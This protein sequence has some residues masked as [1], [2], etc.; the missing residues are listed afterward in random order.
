M[1]KAAE[2]EHMMHLG[3]SD[4]A[5]TDEMIGFHAQQAVEKCLKGVLCLRE[6]RYR[7]THEIA[8][9]LDLL[10]DHGI[11]FP[12]GLEQAV[13]LTP[14]AAEL[15]YDYLPPEREAEGPFDRAAVRQTVRDALEWARG[16]CG[17]GSSD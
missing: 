8:E 14:F 15:R 11:A 3:L 2:D 5:V 13:E 10:R 12:S 9:L 17:Q 4:P 1:R 16:I 7:R 6:V